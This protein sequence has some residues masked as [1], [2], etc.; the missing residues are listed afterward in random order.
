MLKSDGL[1]RVFKKKN[2]IKITTTFLSSHN[3]A[4][5]KLIKEYSK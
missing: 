1:F 3:M 2:L 4:L 5:K